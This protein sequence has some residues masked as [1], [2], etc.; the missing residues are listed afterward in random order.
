MDNDL[1]EEPSSTHMISIS[2]SVCFNKTNESKIEMLVFD[3]GDGLSEDIKDPNSIFDKGVTT[4]YGSGLGLY[5]V[6]HFVEKELNGKII[7]ANNLQ[8]DH[9]SSEKGLRIKIVF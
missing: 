2:F 8:S 6:R 9:N 1:S 5:S 7:V 4:T 3:N